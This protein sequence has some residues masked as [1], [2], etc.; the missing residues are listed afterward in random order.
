MEVQRRGRG[1]GAHRG[2]DEGLRDQLRILTAR[3][4]AVEAGRQ[5]DP[6]LGDDSEDE[7]TTV[8]D[9]SEE[10]APELRLL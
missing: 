3:L 7:A 1:R 5:R 2:E 9:G 8:T 4:E 6:E 10:E